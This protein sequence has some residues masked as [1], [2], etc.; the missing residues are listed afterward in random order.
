MLLAIGL[1]LVVLPAGAQTTPDEVPLED[2]LEVLVIDGE[3]LAFDARNGG[4]RALPLRLAERVLW[5]GSRGQ[6]GVALTDQRILAVSTGSAAW[7]IESRQRGEALPDRALLGDRVGLILTSVRAIG[8]N[9]G[10]GNLVES[11][12]GLREQVLDAR[13]GANVAVVVTDRRA[14]GLSP[15]VGGFF[16][17]P[18]LLEERIESLKAGANLASITTNRRVLIFRATTGS[19]EERVRPL[20]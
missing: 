18:I 1:W 12:L 19:W 3:L 11:R 8:F 10:S 16:E 5:T 17:T 2:V 4:Q 9:G 13:S 6:I 20:D 7:Q 15:L 14:L